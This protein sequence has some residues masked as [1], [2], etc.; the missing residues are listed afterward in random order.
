MLELEF[1]PLGSHAEHPLNPKQI[2]ML[3]DATL[4]HFP[5][6]RLPSILQLTGNTNHSAFARDLSL[7]LFAQRV[8]GHVEA[9]GGP[10]QMQAD[11]KIIK[12]DAVTLLTDPFSED[13]LR[14]A[15]DPT[16]ETMSAVHKRLE[17]DKVVG[18]GLHGGMYAASPNDITGMFADCSAFLFLGFGR[19][20]TMLPSNFFSSE[21]LRHVSLMMFFGRSINDLAFRRQT[22]T[23]SMK[24]QKQ[25]A[26]ESTYGLALMAA[27]R[28]VQCVVMS[29]SPVP[30]A[31]GMRTAETFIRALHSGKSAAKSL[32]DCLNLQTER[33]DLRYLRNLEGGK[34]PTQRYIPTGDGRADRASLLATQ[35]SDTPSTQQGAQKENLLIFHSRSAFLTCGVP[36]VSYGAAAAAAAKK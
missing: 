18:D 22:K 8:R 24:S 34:A 35:P 15:E 32:E 36:W 2:L 27:F 11:Y 17:A 19:F 4:S 29:T 3:P 12:P 1:F 9:E 10:H 30:I 7:H 23:D 31:I 21:D 33:P 16:S 5:L 14:P 28:G 20:F 25:L 6:E 13:T 26:A